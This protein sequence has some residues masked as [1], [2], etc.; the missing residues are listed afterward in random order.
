M[1]A[2]NFLLVGV[3]G[4]GILTA[5]GILA[6]LGVR[7]GY[8]VKKS[9]VH[10]MSQRGGS[11][12][13]HVRLG[14]RVYSPLIGQGEA[15]FLVA[16]EMLEALRWA[17]FLHPQGTALVS[18]QCIP[19]IAVTSGGAHYP[20]QE[21]VRQQL[22]GRARRL[23]MVDAQKVAHELGNPRVMNTVLVGALAALLP[24]SESQ[25]EEIIRE[26]VPARF[27]DLNLRAWRMGLAQVQEN[28]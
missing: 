7:A 1:E 14:P 19:P 5:S 4:Q 10:G 9:E 3:G 17:T 24:F 28:G 20:R 11:V 18:T 2:I 15:N 21:E 12:S 25:W 22:A 16:F 27:A 6:D 26:R 13:S 23:I 8:D